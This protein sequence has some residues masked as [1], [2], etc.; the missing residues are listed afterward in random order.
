MRPHNVA[1]GSQAKNQKPAEIMRQ[2]SAY[3]RFR[4]HE[5]G[6]VAIVR[7]AEQAPHPADSFDGSRASGV[8]LS[9]GT[10]GAEHVLSP[11]HGPDPN[12]GL[13]YMFKLRF[14]C[15]FLPW[16]TSSIWYRVF[17]LLRTSAPKLMAT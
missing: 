13:A 16:L 1:T 8:Q 4:R 5:K 7:A 15:S 10:C 3:A 11:L 17:D 2:Y 12:R 6:R 9:S 14:V